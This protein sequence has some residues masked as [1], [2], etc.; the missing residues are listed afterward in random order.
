MTH[1]HIIERCGGVRLSTKTVK[2]AKKNGKIR[3]I[4]ADFLE[5]ISHVKKGVVCG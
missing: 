3:L 1:E 2:W 4:K 5:G